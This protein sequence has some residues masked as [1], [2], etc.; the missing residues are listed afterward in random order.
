M[1]AHHDKDDRLRQKSTEPTENIRHAPWPARRPDRQGPAD[2]DRA[3]ECRSPN[4]LLIGIA[5]FREDA[6]NPIVDISR[7]DLQICFVGRRR[8]CANSK[9]GWSVRQWRPSPYILK[10]R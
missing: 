3:S 8:P 5:P 9:R 10:L 2:Q 6:A 7:A 1:P 4:Q